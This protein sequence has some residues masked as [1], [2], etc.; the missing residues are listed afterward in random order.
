MKALR[1][2]C[3]P[4]FYRCRYI[5]FIALEI[6]NTIFFLVS[7][8]DIAHRQITWTVSST[9]LLKRSG[10]TLFRS[11]R[12]YFRVGC[13]FWILCLR[14]TRLYFFKAIFQIKLC[15]KNQLFHLFWAL[16]KPFFIRPDVL[17]ADAEW[18]SFQ[19]NLPLSVIVLTCSTFTP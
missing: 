9:G 17:L 2:D 3:I 8:A 4:P 11:I 7:A 19:P 13:L 6:N 14:V 5:V 16:R 10:K 12:G 15:W 18:R 1:F